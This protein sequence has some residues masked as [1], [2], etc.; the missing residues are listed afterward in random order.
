MTLVL[1][2]RTRMWEGDYRRGGLRRLHISFGTKRKSEAGPLHEAVRLLC[3]ADAAYPDLIDRLRSRTLTPAAVA[4]CVRDRRSFDTLR[5]VTRWP[6]VREAAAQYETAIAANPNR[7]ANTLAAARQ[8]LARFCAFSHDGHVCG[9]Y[10]VDELPTTATDAYAAW[11][12]ERFTGSTPVDAVQ[13]IGALYRWLRRREEREARE[14]NRAARPLYIPIDTDA[15]T[16][17]RPARERWLTQDECDALVAA[18]PPR[19]RFPVL[20]GLQAGLRAGEVVM[21]RTGLDVHEGNRELVIQARTAPIAWKPKSRNGV[22]KNRR[23]PMTTM[24]W[25]AYVEHRERYASHD[26]LVTNTRR[27]RL[28]KEVLWKHYAAIVAR[29]GMVPHR[30]TA[31]GVVFHTLRHT[32][33]SHLLMQGADILT[34]ARLLGDTVD[35]VDKTYAHLA[36]SHTRAA[37]RK[38][39]GLGAG[40]LGGVVEADEADATTNDLTAREGEDDRDA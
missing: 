23:V 40:G 32:F 33:A 26:W 27:A 38:I 30:D 8:H 22:N 39:G 35:T 10:R 37:V 15:H 14:T 3:A 34:V 16:L 24:L 1:N 2:R 18:T 19:F 4:A 28:T 29:A 11:L 31:E 20:C 6:T 12:R 36:R 7:A 5:T 13:R 17:A 9:D 21:L 25:G